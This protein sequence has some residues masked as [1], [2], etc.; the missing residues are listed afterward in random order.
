MRLPLRHRPPSRDA[1]LRSCRHLEHLADALR[2]VPLAP[3]A[4]LLD[5]ARGR[6]RHGNAL[7]WHLGL[8]VVDTSPAPDWEER[9]EIKLVSVWQRGD[10]QLKCDRI[11]VCDASCDPWRK[12]ANVLFTK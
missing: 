10:G 9:I 11:K 7:Q 8:E 2:G 3:A 4:E 12:L 5:E 6:G 1:P